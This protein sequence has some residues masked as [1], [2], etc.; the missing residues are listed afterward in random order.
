[1]DKIN[2]LCRYHNLIGKIE[3][4]KEYIAFCN[5]R[6]G[7]IP[8]PSY[9]ERMNN[10]IPSLEAPFVK[11]VYRAI[12]AEGELKRLEEK[13]KSARQEIETSIAALEDETLQMILIYRYIDWLSWIE[14][15]NKVYCSLASVYKKH[16]DAI[17]K[18][19]VPDSM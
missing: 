15:S 8:G 19:I 5:E 17:E 13:A 11:W 10:P 16:R 3:K 1:M 2:Y 9:G 14:I 12:Y 4:K 18:L 6:A 7:S